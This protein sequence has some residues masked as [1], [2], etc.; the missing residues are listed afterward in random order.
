[1]STAKYTDEDLRRVA[2]IKDE[3]FNDQATTI[4]E[5]IDA[6]LGRRLKPIEDDIAELKSDMKVVKA[7]VTDTNHELH[8]LE[9]RVSHLEARA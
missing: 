3:Q 7:A 1:M 4:L 9:Q 2:G 5:N 6:M 8:Q